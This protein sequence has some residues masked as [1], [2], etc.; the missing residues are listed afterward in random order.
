MGGKKR[1]EQIS[2]PRGKKKSGK[3]L[4]YLLIMSVVSKQRDREDK[5]DGF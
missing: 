2:T 3:H 1:E 5:K 4:W